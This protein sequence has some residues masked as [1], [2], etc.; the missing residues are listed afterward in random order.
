MLKHLVLTSMWGLTIFAVTGE[1]LVARPTRAI[2]VDERQRAVAYLAQHIPEA[3]L[4]NFWHQMLDDE[5]WLAK[6]HHGLGKEIR[7]TLRSEFNWGAVKLDSLWSEILTQALETTVLR[8]GGRTP[9]SVNAQRL[10]PHINPARG[11]ALQTVIWA[12]EEQKL[13]AKHFFVAI[14]PDKENYPYWVFELWHRDAF[15]QANW[16]QIG[17]PGGQCRTAYYHRKTERVEKILFWQ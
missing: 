15:K 8:L 11:R 10:S 17:N 7:N 12:L 16:R 9:Q 14:S 5:T 2:S 6:Q 1:N 4:I 3:D 13:D